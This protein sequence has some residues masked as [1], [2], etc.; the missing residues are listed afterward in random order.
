MI[1]ATNSSCTD[2]TLCLENSVIYVYRLG[3]LVSSKCRGKCVCSFLF[4]FSGSTRWGKLPTYNYLVHNDVSGFVQLAQRYLPHHW[5]EQPQP[6]HPRSIRI[7]AFREKDEWDSDSSLIRTHINR[8]PSV[9]TPCITL[10]A[11]VGCA[12]DS[13]KEPLKGHTLWRYHSPFDCCCNSRN[14]PHYS[15]IRSDSCGALS[16]KEEE[17]SPVLSQVPIQGCLKLKIHQRLP[18]FVAG[19]W[20]RFRAGWFR[21]RWFSASVL[22]R[23]SQPTTFIAFWS[24]AL[25]VR[26]SSY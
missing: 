26:W 14:R 2:T 18:R 21:A 22:T 17:S 20:Q 3:S 9:I 10:H 5:Q 1:L 12:A 19:Q 8:W 13:S 11:T 7:S 6:S 23:R 15:W 25:K 16:R 4:S 24:R